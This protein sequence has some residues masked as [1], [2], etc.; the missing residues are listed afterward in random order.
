MVV[1]P[2]GAVPPTP[3]RANSVTRIRGEDERPHPLL[4]R[5]PKCERP[6]IP[7]GFVR[8]ITNN[9]EVQWTNPSSADTQEDQQRPTLTG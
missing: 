8:V 1:D 5:S 2:F 4:P 6:R 9:P 3:I 7:R